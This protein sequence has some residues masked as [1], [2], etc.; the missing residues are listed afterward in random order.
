M[1]SPTF[2]RSA[3]SLAYLSA[4]IALAYSISFGYYVQ[5]GDKWAQYTSSG[6]AK[7]SPS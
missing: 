2:D 4:V 3:S 6:A 1:A 5:E 7:A